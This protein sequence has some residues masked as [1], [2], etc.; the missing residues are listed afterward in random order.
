MTT[1]PPLSFSEF[2]REMIAER[3]RDKIA[4]ARRRGKWTGGPV[5]LGY[6]VVD[7]KLIVNDLEAVVLRELFS[8]YEQHRSALTVARLLNEAG[9][10]TKRHRAKNGNVRAAKKW[11]KDAVLRVLRNPVYAGHMPYGDELHEGEHDG[12]IDRDRYHRLRAILDARGGARQ[13]RARNPAYLLRG[14]LR[15]AHCDGAMT[16]ASTRKN[17]TDY[18]YY[19]CVTRDKEGRNACPARPLPADAVE[20]FVVDRIR[21]AT[22]DGA[23]AADVERQLRARVESRRGRLSTERRDLPTQIA[24]LSAEGRRL[25]EKIGEATGAASGLLDQRIAEVGGELGHCEARLAEVERNLAALDQL[26]IEGKWVAQALA[27]FDSVWDVL[28]SENRA[29]LVRALVRRVEVD[30]TTGDATAILTDV[31]IEDLGHD[32]AVAAPPPRF[33]ASATA[34]EASA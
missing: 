17:G 8:L 13:R 25:V 34:P 16:P 31:G 27:E 30:E 7:K 33:P 5:P 28:T 20:G 29:R 9:R 15:C 24:K 1:A 23:L 32:H 4:A 2:E 22:A 19:R 18:R 6:D 26:E 14:I 11:S 3:T 21:E 12:L 10:S